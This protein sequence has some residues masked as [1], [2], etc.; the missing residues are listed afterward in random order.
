MQAPISNIGCFEEPERRVT[1]VA[2]D[3]LG[4]L[5]SETQTRKSSLTGPKRHNSMST[6]QTDTNRINSECGLMTLKESQR[7]CWSTLG[8]CHF[9]GF[10]QWIPEMW[11]YR[12]SDSFSIS[13][14]SA[15]VLGCP[16]AASSSSSLGACADP[17][18]RHQGYHL[19]YPF[20]NNIM[21]YVCNPCTVNAPLSDT[22]QT[23]I[24]VRVGLAHLPII[25]ITLHPSLHFHHLFKT[26]S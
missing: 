11:H 15:P 14:P 26:I 20:L 13:L 22:W 1:P 23:S 12:V 17:G 6:G 24:V 7:R 10:L 21:S 9:S 16:N 18:K 5:R 4:R 25:I 3:H 19:F 2:F 8:L